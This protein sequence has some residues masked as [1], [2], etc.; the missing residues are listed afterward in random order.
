MEIK[1]RQ[2]SLSDI[3]CDVI[4]VNLF[5]GVKTPGGATGAVDKALGGI[6]SEYV[7]GKDDFKGKLGSTYI[8][9]TYGKIP[10]N[11]V[12]LIGL[13]KAEEFNLNTVR[14]VASKAVKKATS[15]LKAKKIVSILHGAGTAGLSPFD[16]AQMITEG[17]ML[18]AYNFSK[19]KSKDENSEEQKS[20]KIDSFEIVEIDSSK[21]DNINK[22]IQKGKTI[23]CA[24]NFARDLINEP[25]VYA[26]PSKLAEV[27]MSLSDIDC[28]ILE[29]EQ[30]EKMGMGAY[31]A[32]ARGSS[33]PL[34]FIHMT[35]K[36]AGALKKRIA[37][38][39]KGVT[40]DSGGLNLKP[41]NSMLNM[42]DD[43]SGSA[44]VIAIMKALKD[45]KP[46][47]EV[48]GIIAACEN[49][50][51]GNAYKPGDVLK[52]MNGKTI[53]VDNTDAEGRLTLA[54]ALAYAVDLK[55]DQ[56]I[57]MATL[58]GACVVALGSM[59]SGIMGNN[60]ELIDSLIKAGDNGGE[61]LWQ[62]P[63]Y[64]EY[65]DAL[66]SDIADFKNSGGR[67]AGASV[68]GVF[69]KEFVSDTPWAHID[70]AGPAFLEKEIR[71]LSKGGSGAG[72][73]TLINYLLQI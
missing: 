59:A 9:P 36:P 58:T 71:E 56:I 12:L 18:G 62:L 20:E 63:M 72:V 1:A 40:F 31:L 27:A 10:A 24:V 30:I 38:I 73:R 33:E 3:E 46:N 39:G 34:K 51:S 70:I 17:T 26:T 66:K 68:A 2:G 6:I 32:V 13:G 53:E 11:K 55:V 29:E 21:I 64:K 65:M 37:I 45:L 25:A 47:V 60:Q 50:I 67:E 35:Y 54:D 15:V 44:A 42:K 14:E 48:H 7:V 19:Y 4:I 22:G 69:L 57:D 43:M 28:K 8:I 61:R 23:A 5:E 52:A 16:C 49:M 41:G